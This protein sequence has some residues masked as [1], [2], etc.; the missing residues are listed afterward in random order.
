M[1]MLTAF[2]QTVQMQGAVLNRKW[3]DAEGIVEGI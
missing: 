1:P 2:V 3:M